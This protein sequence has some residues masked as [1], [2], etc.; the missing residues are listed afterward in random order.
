MACA[1]L[2]ESAPPSAEVAGDS[3]VPNAGV[4][5]GAGACSAVPALHINKAG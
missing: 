4:D 5:N 3:H 1:A 2:L